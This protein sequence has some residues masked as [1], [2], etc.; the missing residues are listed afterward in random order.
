L[1]RRLSRAAAIKSSPR[2]MRMALHVL[3]RSAPMSNRRLPTMRM[4]ER[5][6]WY[7]IE[8]P[9]QYRSLDC[10][11]MEGSGRTLAIN[12]RLVRFSS[13]QELRVGLNLG[14]LISWPAKLEDGTGLSLWVLG[15]IERSE[16]QQVEIVVCRHQFRT[17]CGEASGAPGRVPT[18]EVTTFGHMTSHGQS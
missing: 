6:T 17:R 1:L 5:S 16:S 9:L 13:D 3:I 4:F 14:L 7:P 10:G 12:S 15:R 2:V 18:L 11:V 8:L